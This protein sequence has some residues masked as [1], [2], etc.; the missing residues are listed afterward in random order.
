MKFF[1][2]I[3]LPLAVC[4]LVTSILFMIYAFRILP[5]QIRDFQR[6]TIETFPTDTWTT[7]VR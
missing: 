2:K 6:Q 3:F 5:T 7:P 4:L 1:L